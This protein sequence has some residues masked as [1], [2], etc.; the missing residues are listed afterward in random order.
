M[1]KIIRSDVRGPRLY[2]GFREDLRKRAIEVKRARRVEVGP[3]V[4]LV[5]EN[6]TTVLFQIEEMLRVEHIEDEMGIQHEIDTYN[7]LVPDPGELSAS[8]FVEITETA[9]I[10]PTLNRLVGLD[11]HVHLDVGEHSV[12]ATFEAGRQEEERISAVQYIRFR[13]P[14]PARA[15]LRAPGTRVRLRIDHPAYAHTTDLDDK[16]RAAL[17]QDLD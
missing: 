8:L 17:A 2:A 3:I 14:E 10:R 16:S 6:R 9:Q 13:L 15:A 1:R 12:R 4:A 7:E 5:F 11:E